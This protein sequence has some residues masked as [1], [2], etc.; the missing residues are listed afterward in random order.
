MFKS[1][2]SLSLPNRLH[3]L[4]QRK[5]SINPVAKTSIQIHSLPTIERVL[6]GPESLPGHVA[7]FFL[8]KPLETDGLLVGRKTELEQLDDAV[9]GWADGNATSA[10][11][12]GPRGSGKTSLINCFLRRQSH[13]QKVIRRRLD[14]RLRTETNVRAFFCGL[15]QIDG[16][17]QDVETVIEQLIQAESR[18][19]VLE[20]VHNLLLRVVGGRKSAELFFYIMM[21]TR[22]R[23]CWLLSCRRLPWDNMDWLFGASH[24]FSHV[25]PVDTL[26]QD[27]LREALAARL[28]KCGVEAKFRD[29]KPE[30]A[31]T[32][33]RWRRFPD[34]APFRCGNIRKYFGRPGFRASWRCS[35][36]NN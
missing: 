27:N 30:I 4:F 2:V 34:T 19:V 17:G 12:V 28:E 35:I 1:F 29:S 32:C 36:W 26:S 31:F 3:G 6:E 14:E 33:F 7:R 20:G 13:A 22:Q 21:R 16:T 10:I 9:G 11:L 24:Y 18:M 5:P 25:I 8:P 15:F 23:H